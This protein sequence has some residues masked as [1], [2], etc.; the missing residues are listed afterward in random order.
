MSNSYETKAFQESCPYDQDIILHYE[1]KVQLKPM[2]KNPTLQR[3]TTTLT[4]PSFTQS[5]TRSNTPPP[6]PIDLDYGVLTD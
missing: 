4:T 2:G 6:P 1:G 3:P 5:S